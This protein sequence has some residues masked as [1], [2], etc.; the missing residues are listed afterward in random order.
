MLELTFVNNNPVIP[1]DH[2]EPKYV[3]KVKLAKYSIQLFF[4]A[5][6]RLPQEN[7][8]QISN[9]LKSLTHSDIIS[10]FHNQRALID[11]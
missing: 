10:Y 7:E 2:L 9:Y 3:L 8:G 6:I 11:L 4:L 5:E 1:S